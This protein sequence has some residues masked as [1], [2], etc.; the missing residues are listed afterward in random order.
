MIKCALH[1]VSRLPI[2]TY[3]AYIDY[4]IFTINNC[5]ITFLTVFTHPV[6]F[7]CGR[8]P[9]HQE[10]THVD[11]LVTWV[12]SENRTHELRGERYLFWRHRSP[13]GPGEFARWKLYTVYIGRENGPDG[14]DTVPNLQDSRMRINGTGRI[15]LLQSSHERHNLHNL[16]YIYPN[17]ESSS[18]C[19]DERRNACFKTS[20]TPHLILGFL[21]MQSS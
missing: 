1:Q 18:V 12:G 7:P 19:M 5:D 11:W 20:S 16:V 14:H 13:T 8:K 17:T 4:F 15:I 21:Q 2:Y 6:N 9:E 3:W 10:K